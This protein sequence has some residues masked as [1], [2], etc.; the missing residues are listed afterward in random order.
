MKWIPKRSGLDVR[1]LG[2]IPAFLSENDPRPAKEQVDA[3]YSHGGGWQSF[4][5]FT[6]LPN[7]DMLYP[8]DPVTRCLFE[9]RLRDETI[10]FYEHAWLAIVQ[11]DGTFDVARI[12]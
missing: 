12:D 4:P 2:Y 8:G 5:G 1:I 11:P 7:G 9:T 3:A 10:R 6:M